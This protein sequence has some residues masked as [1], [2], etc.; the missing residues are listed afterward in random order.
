[1]RADPSGSRLREDALSA[2]VRTPIARTSKERLNIP[3]SIKRRTVGLLKFSKHVA[4][5]GCWFAR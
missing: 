2:R 3:D 5:E 1:R 4:V